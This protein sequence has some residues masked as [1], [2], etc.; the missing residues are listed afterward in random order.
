MSFFS[1]SRLDSIINATMFGLVAGIIH[2][3][4]FQY[5][6]QANIFTTLYGFGILN[7]VFV[8]VEVNTKGRSEHLVH[9]II[10]SS[11]CISLFNTIY[12]S[13][14]EASLEWAR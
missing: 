14:F 6:Y 8:I 1:A 5:P 11:V 2:H 12:V 4:L 10:L 3:F 9:Q 7:T 13:P